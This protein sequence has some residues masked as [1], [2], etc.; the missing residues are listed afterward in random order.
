MRLEEKI[1]DISSN[2]ALANK[3][4]TFREVGGSKS[5]VELDGKTRDNE[6]P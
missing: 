4:R 1:T 6:D 5:E 2:M 3:F